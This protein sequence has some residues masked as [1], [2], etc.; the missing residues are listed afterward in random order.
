MFYQILNVVFYKIDK[1]QF[2]SYK[3]LDHHVTFIIMYK[4]NWKSISAE[5]PNLF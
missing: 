3:A 5:A 1:A 4:E 2:W